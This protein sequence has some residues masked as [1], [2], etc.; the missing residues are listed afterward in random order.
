[1]TGRVEVSMEVS[2]C[3]TCG[4]QF[5]GTRMYCGQ[6]CKDLARKRPCAVCGEP[7]WVTRGATTTTHKKCQPKPEHG[8]QA[9]YASG[10]RCQECRD[11][12]ARSHRD[13]MAGRRAACPADLRCTTPGC[14]ATRKTDGLC[15][16]HLKRK[17]RAD[18]TWKPSPADAWDAPARVARHKARKATLRG[19]TGPTDLFTVRDLIDRDGTDCGICG[20]PIPDTAYP[21][22]SSASIDHITPISL[23]GTHTLTN[24][25]ATHL[26]CN[27]ARGNRD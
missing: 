1:M 3:K 5:K 7:A 2:E 24:A 11:E 20:G 16:K 23:G 10:C 27:I 25:R 26:R 14:A 22:P 4:E 13:Y 15:T 18:G 8:T 17:Q 21:D 6:R 9:R 19:A 12:V